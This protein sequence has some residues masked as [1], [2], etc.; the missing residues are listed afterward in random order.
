M[1]DHPFFL[2]NFSLFTVKY[3]VK[4]ESGQKE[5]NRHQYRCESHGSRIKYNVYKILA[6]IP[7]LSQL[8]LSFTLKICSLNSHFII[9]YEFMSMYPE[10]S[11]MSDFGINFLCTSVQV[12]IRDNNSCNINDKNGNYNNNKIFFWNTVELSQLPLFRCSPRT[13]CKRHEIRT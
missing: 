2:F 9:V 13:D 5:M 10:R 4:Y 8:N 3:I 1:L 6:L 11:V 12:C 7:L